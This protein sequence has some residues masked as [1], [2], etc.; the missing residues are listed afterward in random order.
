[1]AKE[2]KQAAPEAQAAPE[3]VLTAE[4]EL[5]LVKEQLKSANA[6]LARAGVGENIEPQ[7]AARMR[8]G[9]SREDAIVCTRREAL[10]EQAVKESLEIVVKGED[11]KVDEKATAGARNSFLAAALVEAGGAA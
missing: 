7:V 5:S 2:P 8:M 4:Q 6:R 1:M 3:V 10:S 11:G 9:L